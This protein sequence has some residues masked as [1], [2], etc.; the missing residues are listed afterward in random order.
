MRIGQDRR[1]PLDPQ[2]IEFLAANNNLDEVV[3]LD[4]CLG[5]SFAGLDFNQTGA[6]FAVF[7]R[8][9]MLHPRHYPSGDRYPS[10]PS[11]SNG[12]DPEAAHVD[13]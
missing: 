7:D 6:V 9:G 13:V 11:G 8:W 2:D 4:I 10:S 1:R 3:V 5:L 12:T